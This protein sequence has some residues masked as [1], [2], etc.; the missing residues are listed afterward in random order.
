MRNGEIAWYHWDCATYI[1]LKTP[2]S[3]DRFERLHVHHYASRIRNI[4][5]GLGRFMFTYECNFGV[6]CMLFNRNLAV[7]R[8][9][10]SY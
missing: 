1:V 8:E 2:Y 7:I 10:T 4:H 3:V 6:I 9:T 5:S